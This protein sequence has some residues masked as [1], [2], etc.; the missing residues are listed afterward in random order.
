MEGRKLHSD[1]MDDDDDD[2]GWCGIVKLETFTDQVPHTS[3]VGNIL[4]PFMRAVKA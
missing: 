4:Y 3:M 2:A 1:D